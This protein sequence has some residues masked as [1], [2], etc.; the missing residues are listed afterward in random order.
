MKRF[1]LS[2]I[3]V[4]LLGLPSHA[5]LRTLGSG[6]ATRFDPAGLPPDMQERYEKIMRVRCVKCHTLERVVIAVRTGVAPISGLP[7]NKSSTRAYGVKMLLKTDSDMTK[8]ET[9]EVIILLNYLLDEAA[10]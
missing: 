2:I 7:F 8:P 10:R 1:F 3:L 9:R 4:L 5:G 6:K